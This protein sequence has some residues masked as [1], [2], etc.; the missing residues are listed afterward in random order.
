MFVVHRY[1]RQVIDES[2]MCAVIAPWTARYQDFDSEL[3]GHKI[4]KNTPVIH[5]LGV[6]LQNEKYFPLPN[7]AENSKSRPSYSFQRFGFAGKRKCPADI[8]A[9]VEGTITLFSILRKFKIKMVE[10]QV[11]T[12]T[13]GFVTHPTEEVWI[14]LQ[15]R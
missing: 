5:A 6:S 13:F 14:T 12:P 11:V 3:G 9:Y 8:F 7:N 1:L 15:K 2:L 10:G 4:P